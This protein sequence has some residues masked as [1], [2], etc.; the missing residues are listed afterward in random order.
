MTLDRAALAAGQQPEALVE[1]LRDLCRAQH[2][3]TRCGELDRQR[4]AV[5]PTHDLADR[6][7]DRV[8]RVEVRLHRDRAIN[9]QSAGLTPRCRVVIRGCRQAER[10]NPDEALAG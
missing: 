1:S 4:Y 2:G 3:D 7:R 6:G 10:T 9:E 5:E 8:G